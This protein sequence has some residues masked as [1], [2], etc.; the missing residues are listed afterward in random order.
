MWFEWEVPHHSLVFEQLVPSW[1]HSLGGCVKTGGKVLLKEVDPWVWALTF[2][3]QPHFLF[4]L[5]SSD[6]WWMQCISEPLEG[7]PEGLYCLQVWAKMNPS[8]HRFFCLGILSA[9][10][11]MIKYNYINSY[12]PNIW[13]AGQPFPPDLHIYKVTIVIMSHV[14]II[15]GMFQG[16]IFW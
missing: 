16:S 11:K 6:C 14:N 4:P 12:F 2:I 3:V 8:F 9:M 5:L 10:R 7:C 15:M 1:W 13:K